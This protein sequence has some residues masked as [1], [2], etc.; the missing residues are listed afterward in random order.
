M[1]GGARLKI[2]ITDSTHLNSHYTQKLWHAQTEDSSSSIMHIFNLGMME[3][4]TDSTH[5]N[6]HY[7][8]TNKD[9]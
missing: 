2:Y 4:V 6:S 1:V 9:N 8:L 5:L 7:C 3:G